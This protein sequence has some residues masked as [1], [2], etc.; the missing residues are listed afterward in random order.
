MTTISLRYNERNL[1]AQKAIDYIL[2]LG[3]FTQ[4]SEMSANKRKTLQAIEDVRAGK[5]VTVCNTFEEY[6]KAIS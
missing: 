2:S 4:A 1:L 3:F 6:K 5:D